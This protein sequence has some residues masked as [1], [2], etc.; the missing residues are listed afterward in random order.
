MI[1]EDYTI[2]FKRASIKI[3][4]RSLYKILAKK[5]WKPNTPLTMMVGITY[6]CQ[7]N[8]VHCCVKGYKINKNEELSAIQ[9]KNLIDDAF[10]LGVVKVNF[11]GGEPTLRRD[12]KDL[13]NYSYKKGL[14]THLETNGINLT[15]KEIKEIKEAGISCINISLDNPDPRKHDA[16]RKKDGCFRKA[17]EA[18]S[19]VVKEDIPC[20]IST[21]V[22]KEKVN[23][24][25]LEEMIS[26]GKKLGVDQIRLLFPTP[27]GRW[28]NRGDIVLPEHEK[29]YIIKNFVDYKFVNRQKHCPV[30]TKNLFYVSPYG[31]VQPCCF[32]PISFGNIQ[33][34]CLRSIWHRMVK[35]QIY[36]T[37][38]KKCI[39]ED[40]NF[41]LKIVD[42]LN[43]KNIVDYSGFKN[44]YAE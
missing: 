8:C 24:N 5:I 11:F 22:S 13:I 19:N 18:I 34:E 35:S 38:S 26:L 9:I 39:M 7:C 27:S 37:D 41:R 3:K 44:E 15:K 42:S 21:Y 4:I 23:H 14:I 30:I 28:L 2:N 33:E 20:I 32:I 1:K 10:E 6:R 43:E 36:R 12:L 17:V 16:L 31:E 40:S 29:K 25:E